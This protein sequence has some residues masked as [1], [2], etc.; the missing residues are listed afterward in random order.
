MSKDYYKSLGVGKGASKDEIKSA[1]RKLA[2][3]YHPDKKDGNA[4]KFK[5]INEAYSVLSDDA[6]RKQY[7]TFGSAGPNMGGSGFRGGQGFGGFDFSGFAQGGGQGFEFDFG[8][9]FSDFFGGGGRG[10]RTPR[11]RDISVDIDV[12]F[13]DSVFGA[14]KTIAFTKDAS[15]MT[16]DG[17]GAKKGTKLKTCSVCNGQGKVKEVRRTILGNVATTRACDECSGTGKIPEEKCSNC[18]GRGI[19]NRKVEVKIRI[20]GGIESGESLRVSG[21]GEAIAGGTAGDLYIK[22]FIKQHPIFRKEGANLV[23]DL[24]LKVSEALLGVEKT[25]TTLDGTITLKIPE[26]TAH[27]ELLRVKGKGVAV[28]GGRRGD[29][30]V[31]IVHQMPKKVSREARKLLEE[32]GKE[33]I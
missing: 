17:S 9:V 19:E 1:F 22:V 32:L 28:Q 25:I 4:D 24:H 12:P 16:C 6:K 8:D 2:H 15:C 10:S 26:A 14:E 18:A 33:G 5:E 3:Q 27:H 23:M 21:E 13:E 20:P 30:I 29:L 31:R 11:G 7:D